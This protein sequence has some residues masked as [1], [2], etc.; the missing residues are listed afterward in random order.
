MKNA[1]LLED[2]IQKSGYKKSYL[3]TALGLSRYGFML[4]CNNKAEF[5]ASEIET[6]CN[7]L[8]IDTND[9]MAIFFAK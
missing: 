8:D 9:R 1:S 4:K 7:L 5:R 3:A 6:L 2:Y